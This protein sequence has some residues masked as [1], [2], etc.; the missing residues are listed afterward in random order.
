MFLSGKVCLTYS[1]CMQ[2]TLLDAPFGEPVELREPTVDAPLRLRLAELGLR[3]GRTVRS[4]R[5][6]TGG[7][8]VVAVG[9]A[10]IALDRRTCRALPYLLPT[11]ATA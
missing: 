2:S 3:T 8:R 11:P 4:V 5:A 6:T 10:Q 7:G 1:R 9:K